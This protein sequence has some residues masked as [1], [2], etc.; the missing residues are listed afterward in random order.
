M[1][2][3]NISLRIAIALAMGVAVA[4][5][6]MASPPLLR[7]AKDNW[8]P[9][10]FVTHTLMLIISVLLMALLS[11]GR[12]SSYGFTRGSFRMT[13]TIILWM[14]PTS[15]LSVLQFVAMKSGGPTSDMFNLSRAQVILFVWIYAS[16]CEEV[17]VRGLLQGYLFPLGQ[18]KVTL[19]RQWPLSVP[20]LFGGLFFGAMHIVLWPKMGPLAIMPMSLAT[21]LGIVAGYYREKT[22]SLFPAI[23]IHGLFNI[24][25]SLPQWVLIAFTA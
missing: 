18:Y 15:F 24:G 1:K 4:V 13:P 8:L 14:I 23:L 19:F 5:I 9:P 16:T 7:M 2:P 22:G 25:G 6:A 17:F 12:L 3:E 10:S 20:V 11:K 21:G